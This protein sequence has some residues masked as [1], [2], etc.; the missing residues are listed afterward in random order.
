M[1]TDGCKKWLQMDVKNGDRW[2]YKMVTDGCKK[3]A[4]VKSD[5]G[6]LIM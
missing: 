1:V 5:L 4:G 2:M 3:Q 6:D